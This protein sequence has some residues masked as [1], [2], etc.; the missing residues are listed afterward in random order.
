LPCFAFCLSA[1]S[2]WLAILFF[3]ANSAVGQKPCRRFSFCKSVHFYLRSGF[4]HFQS[5]GCSRVVFLL[6]SAFSRFGFLGRCGSSGFIGSCSVSLF[7][8]CF[9]FVG[10]V[11]K[12][13]FGFF[14]SG[15]RQAGF[16]VWRFSGGAFFLASLWFYWLLRSSIFCAI[17]TAGLFGGVSLA[18]PV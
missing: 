2:G 4:Q 6:L 13:L 11:A 12:S 16:F 15:S 5:L 3:I 18:I 17:I 9:S 1:F 14:R 7:R 8:V 10:F